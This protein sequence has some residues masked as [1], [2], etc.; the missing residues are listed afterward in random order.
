MLFKQ[1]SD[2]AERP[3]LLDLT[4]RYRQ[5]LRQRQHSDHGHLAGRV[6]EDQEPPEDEGPQHPIHAADRG[7][8]D[9]DLRL[10]LERR[11]EA[12]RPR[13]ASHGGS[14]YS[15]GGSGRDRQL[16][17]RLGPES[18]RQRTDQEQGTDHRLRARRS[19]PLGAADG[20]ASEGRSTLQGVHRG[21]ARGDQRLAALGS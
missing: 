15:G 10:G 18:R 7:T 12:T 3:Q 8:P 6:L 9:V 21:R 20:V 5:R 14:Q 11:L 1:I 13:N 4:E 2:E 19:S 17:V 16:P